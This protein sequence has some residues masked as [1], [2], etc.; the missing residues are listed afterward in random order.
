MI[1]TDRLILNKP[2]L[3]DFD[4]SYAMSSDA[5]VTEFIGGKPA[6]REDAWN[7]LL[8]NI[9]HWK[10][11][12]FGIFTV[13]EKE[14]GGFVGE[15]GLAHFARGLGESF[16]PFPEAAWVLATS[17]H[18]KGY[19]AEAVVAAHDWMTQTHQP[20]RTVCIIHPGNAASMRLAAKLGYASFGEAQYRGA[21]PIMFERS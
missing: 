7:K 4:E 6:S 19:G 1:E 5:A 21:S 18:G 15:V 13:R 14:S 10:T 16:D 2:S 11:F 20:V 3:I 9:G 12:E 8:R 17:G